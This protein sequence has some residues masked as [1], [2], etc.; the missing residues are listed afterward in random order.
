MENSIKEKDTFRILSI[1]GGGIKG[2]YSASVLNI[3]EKQFEKDIS[4][5]FDLICGTSTGGL[6]ALALSIGIKAEDLCNIYKE[7]ASIIFSPRTNFKCL[8]KINNLIG[9]FRQG[10]IGSK[11]KSDGLINVLN[12]MFAEKQIKDAKTSL[13][14]PITDLTSCVPRV[15]KTGHCSDY[16][17]DPDL[18]MKDVA[19][20]T[21]AA[22]TFFDSTKI[23]G[24]GNELIDGGLH[25]N[26]P[27]IIG[28]I[29]AIKCFVGDG[30]KY[31]KVQLLSIASV[32][33]SAGKII[34]KEKSRSYKNWGFGLDLIENIMQL[35]TKANQNYIKLLGQNLPFEIQ[36]I[37][38]PE[39]NMSTEQI[40]KLSLDATDKGS[41]ETLE[42]LG[43]DMGYSWVDKEDI[44]KMFQSE[45]TTI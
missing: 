34:T 24:V 12:E 16:K 3:F 38:I 22:P 19:L 23:E 43:I 35:Q 29:E 31:K 21:T 32:S 27:S 37:R 28:L 9:V 4:N 1:D 42:S 6:I 17:R 45:I 11:Y 8:G 15:I 13:C 36:Y 7:K 44:K 2:L 39:P 25:A 26:D 14:I 33:S 40:K 5:C 18:L 20:A 30:K 41:L 10:F